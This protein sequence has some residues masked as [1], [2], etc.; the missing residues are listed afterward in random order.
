[1]N[2]S[3]LVCAVLGHRWAVIPAETTTRG[4]TY[5]PY[6]VCA[7]GCS[8]HK[9]LVLATEPP[10]GHPDSM[11]R[12]LPREQEALLGALDAELFPQEA[13]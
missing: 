3:S 7:R 5:S 1:V 2:L 11:T 6:R 12:E 4:D 8:T 9:A 13:K 10:A